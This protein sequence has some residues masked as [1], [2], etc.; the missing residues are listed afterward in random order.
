MKKAYALL[1]GDKMIGGFH[2]SRRSV[3]KNYPKQIEKKGY[4]IGVFTLTGTVDPTE[5]EE[6]TL[7]TDRYGKHVYEQNRGVLVAVDETYSG[8][9]DSFFKF[10][11][12]EEAVIRDRHDTSIYRIKNFESIV[13]DEK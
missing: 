3:K 8:G 12:D 4:S 9:V 10:T 5:V 13:F 1:K 7:W 2:N 11:V 6:I